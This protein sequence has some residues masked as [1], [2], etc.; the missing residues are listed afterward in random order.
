M[1]SCAACLQGILIMIIALQ[2]CL[3]ALRNIILENLPAQ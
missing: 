1:N 2:D 3:K